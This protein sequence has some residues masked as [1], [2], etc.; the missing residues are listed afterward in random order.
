[1]DFDLRLSNAAA[2]PELADNLSDAVP[3]DDRHSIC[4]TVQTCCTAACS[5]QRASLG[6]AE[7]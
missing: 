4:L 3:K 6:L 5:L 2:C 7:G 1:M